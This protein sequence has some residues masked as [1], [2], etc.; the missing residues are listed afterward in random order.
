MLWLVIFGL[1]LNFGGLWV[2]YNGSY[3]FVFVSMA[4]LHF[5]YPIYLWNYSTIVPLVVPRY[6]L[7]PFPLDVVLSLSNHILN[8]YLNIICIL[9]EKKDK[10][11]PPVRETKGK[12]EKWPYT[13]L[14]HRFFRHFYFAISRVYVI[15]WLHYMCLAQDPDD[16]R[17]HLSLTSIYRFL[18][19]IYSSDFIIFQSPDSGVDREGAAT[20]AQVCVQYSVNKQI[21]LLV[22]Y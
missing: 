17:F 9:D 20:P 7:H 5:Y 13:S 4:Y 21:L 8:Y 16:I 15:I 2:W 11:S 19:N 22:Q 12:L 3:Q 10:S 14:N 1:Y 6:I 18:A